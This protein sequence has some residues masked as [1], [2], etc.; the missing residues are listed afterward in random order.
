MLPYSFY[1]TIKPHTI[2]YQSISRTFLYWIWIIIILTILWV[3]IKTNWR[4]GKKKLTFGL[5]DFVIRYVSCFLPGTYSKTAFVY[6]SQRF[7]I[8]I[9]GF[10]HHL[11]GGFETVNSWQMLFDRWPSPS[12]PIS[13]LWVES[14]CPRL[15]LR[16]L[17]LF[18]VMSDKQTLDPYIHS[19]DFPHWECKMTDACLTSLHTSRGRNTTEQRQRHLRGAFRAVQR[20]D[21][22][23]SQPVCFHYYFN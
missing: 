12:F 2:N 20:D 18:I 16:H 5:V 6:P 19:P 8:A 11:R 15:S 17:I 23:T 9:C 14:K 13:R 4:T 22:G 7:D 21:S 3:L 1:C 10:L